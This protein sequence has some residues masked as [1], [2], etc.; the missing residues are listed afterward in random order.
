MNALENC[1]L[2]KNINRSDY[3]ISFYGSRP[4]LILR[5][6]DNQ[7]DRL[8]GL[9]LYASLMDEFQDVGPTVWDEIV[10][11]AL[12]RNRDWRALLIGTPK[13]RTSYFYKIHEQAL[14]EPDWSYFHFHTSHNP[15]FPKTHLERARRELP[16][17]VFRQEF[18]ASWEDFEGAL[19]SAIERHHIATEVPDSFRSVYLGVDWG[20]I[21]PAMVVVGLTHGGCYY[22]LDFWKNDSGL[23]I[24][25][26]MLLEQAAK[27]AKEY[28]IYRPFLPDDRPG[29]I[30]SFRRYG[31]LH[32]VPA[33][34]RSVEVKRSKPSPMERVAIGDSLF[35]QNRLYFTPKT[36]AL[37]DEF[38]SYHREK[39][40]DGNLLNKPAK[41]QQDHCLDAAMHVIGTLEFKHGDHVLNFAQA[42]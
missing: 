30:L 17:K 22:L 34:Q 6:C 42:A 26:P 18:E 27:F 8:R 41:G 20:D 33:L 12:A 11:P 31:K 24:T 13:G 2:V 29:S 21:N 15:F 10:F 25:E 36:A 40:S 7:G 39:D 19:F 5:G 28:N 1:P 37:F 9:N 16:P 23:P 38:S 32:S 4:D 35:Y 14:R 3:R